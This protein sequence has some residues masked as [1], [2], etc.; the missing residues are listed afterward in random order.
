MWLSGHGRE[1]VAGIVKSQVG[2]LVPLKTHHAK[3]LMFFKSVETRNPHIVV[4]RKVSGVPSQMSSSSLDCDSKLPLVW[5][6]CD[7]ITTPHKCLR[8]D[9]LIHTKSFVSPHVGMNV[10]NG[11]LAPVSTSSPD[12]RGVFSMLRNE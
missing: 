9:S 12:F 11:M 8:V 6:K 1:F 5:V 2:V 7:V 4:G 3:W 10:D